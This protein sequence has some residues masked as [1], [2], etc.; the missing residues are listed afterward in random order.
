MKKKVIRK[1]YTE[2]F[3]HQIVQLYE[4]GK[5]RRDIMKEYEITGTSIDNWVKRYKNSGS[6]Q[7]KDNRSKEELELKE[8]KRRNKELE[9][10]VDILKQAALIIGRK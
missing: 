8:L 10:E 5:R 7:I 6:F 1:Y 2:E 3:K 4:N 9:M